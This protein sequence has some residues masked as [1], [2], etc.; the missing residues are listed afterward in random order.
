MKVQLKISDLE[1]IIKA[2]KTQ[3]ESKDYLTA[4]IEIK[5]VSKCD[6]HAGSDTVN[7]F[8]K[9]AYA[10]CISEPLKK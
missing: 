5:Q 10:E 7:V 4:T 2:A 8:V 6:T 1:A 9:S 3:V